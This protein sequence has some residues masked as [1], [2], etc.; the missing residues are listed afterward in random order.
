VQDRKVPLGRARLATASARFASHDCALIQ[1]SLPPKP[2]PRSLCSKAAMASNVGT[3]V[4]SDFEKTH[5][6]KGF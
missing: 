2:Y 3:A 1:S 6:L 5:H 4:A